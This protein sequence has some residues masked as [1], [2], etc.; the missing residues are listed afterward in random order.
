MKIFASYFGCLLQKIQEFSH[1]E[2]M[3]V[4]GGGGGITPVILCSNQ[5]PPL[6]INPSYVHDKHFPDIWSNL[7]RTV[8][9]G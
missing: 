4:G 7:T 9:H 5:D 6:V 1:E 2:E 3:A 8:Q